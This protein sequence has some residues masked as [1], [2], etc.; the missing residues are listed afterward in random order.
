MLRQKLCDFAEIK[1][2]YTFRERVVSVEDGDILVIQPKDLNNPSYSE[3]AK[4]PFSK[5]MSKHLLKKGDV[6]FSNRGAFSSIVYD[7][8]YPT[9]GSGGFFIIRVNNKKALPEYISLFLNSDM[10][11]KIFLKI[12]E[13]MTIP[14]LTRDQVAG[15]EIPLPSITKQEELIRFEDLQKKEYYLMQNLLSLKKQRFNA[16]IKGVLYG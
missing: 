14:A 15:M 8:K 4:I 5:N 3:M 9:V 10:A 16:I 1:S 13:S 7:G 6:L 11:Q 12:Q 2:G